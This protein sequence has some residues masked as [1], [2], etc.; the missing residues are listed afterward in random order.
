MTV[1]AFLD[2]N[3]LIYA[4]DT[5]PACVSKRSRALGILANKDHTLII[6]P[7]VLGEFYVNIVGKLEYPLTAE[8]A[9]RV[10][11][12]TSEL[13]CITIDSSLVAAAIST[14]VEAQLSYWDA[15]IVEAAARAKCEILLTEDLNEGA[16]IRGVRIV[17]PFD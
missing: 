9:A 17:N 3:I 2:S 1:R 14:S 5:D 16:T 8:Q 4:F 10:V 7:Q 15:L 13:E 11:A 6:S 12:E